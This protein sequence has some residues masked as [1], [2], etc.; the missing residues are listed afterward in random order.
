MP[1]CL[2]RSDYEDCLIV[3]FSAAA[4]TISPYVDDA[5]RN[6]LQEM[7]IAAGLTWG[8]AH[9]GAQGVG[10]NAPDLIAPGIFVQFAA[11]NG[12]SRKAGRIEAT[13]IKSLPVRMTSCQHGEARQNEECH[14]ETRFC[15]AFSGRLHLRTD[16]ELCTRRR[17]WSRCRSWPWI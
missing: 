14:H 11:A 13:S 6:D 10:A 4:K 12:Y 2:Q 15:R 9:S 16:N 8:I 1:S 17:L 3:L 7:L 5:L